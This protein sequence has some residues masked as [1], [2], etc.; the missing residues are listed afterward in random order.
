M[1]K[2]NIIY[3]KRFSIDKAT[4]SFKVSNDGYYTFIVYAPESMFEENK[5]IELENDFI[6]ISLH[7]TKSK[8]KNLN[9]TEHL[10][11]S[12]FYD[13]IEGGVKGWQYRYKFK[14][15]LLRKELFTKSNKNPEPIKTIFNYV[16]N[17]SFNN[18]NK[19]MSLYN[20]I[21]R[22]YTGGRVSPK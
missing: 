15:D 13:I 11:M 9:F 14:P 7:K 8:N 16:D 1:E 5:D 4:F 6:K 12:M 18:K 3:R 17:R 2:A 20:N 21:N 10:K 19:D 22:P